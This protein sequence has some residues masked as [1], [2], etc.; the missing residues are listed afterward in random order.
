V[1]YLFSRCVLDT[2]ARELRRE[3]VPVPLSPLGTQ[4]LKL[5]LEARPRALRHGELR[6]ALW[7]STTVGYT[8]LARVVSEVRR[9]IGDTRSDPLVR[10]VPRF[11]YAFA[12]AVRTDGEHAGPSEG[13][14]LVAR[15][16]EYPL[17]EGESLIGRGPECA[18]QLRRAQVSR[19]HAR[20]CVKG[21]VASIED[22]GSKNGTWINGV[23]ATGRVTL[24]DGDEVLLGT[25]RVVFRCVRAADTT[26][27]AS[28]LAAPERGSR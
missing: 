27:S 2:A 22:L 20:V 4:L 8:S 9:A 28:P 15:D 19:V 16:A 25:V 7:P 6:D 23:R 24:A 12:G 14:V 26:R 10:T 13:S 11:G 5:L 3:D 21:T 1:R 18:I 17:A